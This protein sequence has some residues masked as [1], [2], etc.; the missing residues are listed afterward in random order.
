M[1]FNWALAQP[2]V[3]AKAPTGLDVRGS[4]QLRPH[5]MRSSDSLPSTVDACP[6]SSTSPV[7]RRGD[8]DGR[9]AIPRRGPYAAYAR[10]LVQ[11]YGPD[12]SFW[13]GQHRRQPIRQWQIWNEPN[14][15][16]FWPRPFAEGTSRS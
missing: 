10:A 4:D 13:T 11:R 12:G 8:K 9:L 7:G 3:P 2:S 6:T 1:A 14:L 16:F 15:M 5:S